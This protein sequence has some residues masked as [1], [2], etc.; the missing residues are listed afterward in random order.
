MRNKHIDLYTDGATS[1]NGTNKAR[2]GWGYIYNS[3]FGYKT[4]YGG[5]LNT[6]NNRMELTAILK[7]IEAVLAQY[8]DCEVDMCIYSDSAYVINCYKDEWYKKWETNGWVNT[9]RKP[10]ANKDLWEKLIPYFKDK[11]FEFY[12]VKGHSTGN[13]QAELNNKVDAL[14]KMGANS[15]K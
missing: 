2:G 15:I 14:A 8:E 9:A 10:V 1:G 12:K 13:Q 3:D 6:T 7:G 4:G 5:E 11:R